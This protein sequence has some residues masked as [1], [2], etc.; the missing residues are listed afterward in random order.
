MISSTKKL[1]LRL[2]QSNPQTIVVKLSKESKLLIKPA[3][4][5]KKT[6]VTKAKI[7]SVIERLQKTL[8]QLLQL[9]HLSLENQIQRV[10]KI[11]I[12]VVWIGLYVILVK[13]STITIKI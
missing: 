13:S 11:K 9:T 6:D 7:M 12:K 8:P 3:R 5:R 2:T 1:K 4:I 10:E